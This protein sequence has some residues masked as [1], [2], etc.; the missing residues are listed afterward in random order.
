MTRYLI[1]GAAGMLGRDLQKALAG[2]DVT[3]FDRGELDITD[4]AA[5]QAAVTGFDV[6]INAAAYTKVDDAETNEDAAYLLNAVG[7][8]NLARAAQASGARLV[9]ISTD[10]VFEGNATSPYQEDAPA[11]P[12][13]AYGRTKAAGE[14]IVLAENPGKTYIVRTAWLYGKN[15]PNF[16]KTMLK[17]A[18]THDTLNVVEDQV[19][20]PTW[21]VD[22]ANQIVAL[23]DAEAPAG[24]YHGT[25]SGVTSWFGFAQ[26][27]LAAN[28]LDPARVLPTDGASFVRPAPRPA[29]SV[30]GH[31]AW[32]TAGL[33]PMRD[34]HDALT[35]AVA[36][37]VL[38]TE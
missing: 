23:L 28:G 7:P 9:Q 19:G 8:R 18:A 12:I 31:D 32:A 29:Y 6:V 35:E 27:V 20:Q 4:Q 15:G 36:E 2:R 3:A 21:T 38:E 26:A 30:L 13:S 22:L 1:T 10:Y 34:W 25:S 33:T 14:E 37:G 11:A 24:I 16:P 5:V 17:L